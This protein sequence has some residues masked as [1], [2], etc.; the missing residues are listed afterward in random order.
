MC[1]IPTQ[2]SFLMQKCSHLWPAGA[3][4]NGLLRSF[5]MANILF[6]FD[7]TRCSRLFKKCILNWI[8][9]SRMN[10]CSHWKYSEKK[11]WTLSTILSLEFPQILWIM[12]ASPFH[13]EVERCWLERYNPHQFMS[14]S[15]C[16][17]K[18]F[19]FFPH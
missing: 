5:D 12:A 3:P 11:L 16:V 10:I 1:F 15:I 13:Q 4:S 7:M 18:P 19:I 17:L 8:Y 2:L 14:S 6:C 9:P